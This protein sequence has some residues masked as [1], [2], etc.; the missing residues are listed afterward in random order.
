VL[1]SSAIDKANPTNGVTKSNRLCHEVLVRPS[2]TDRRKIVNNNRMMQFFEDAVAGT[3]VPDLTYIEVL[4]ELKAK[5]WCDVFTV[6]NTENGGNE[7]ISFL[8]ERESGKT[9]ARVY[10]SWAAK[11]LTEGRY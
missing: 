8:V 5:M 11:V 1:L 10:M 3:K 2:D 9:I 4:A 6:P 7:M